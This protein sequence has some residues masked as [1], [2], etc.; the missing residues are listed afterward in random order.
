MINFTHHWAIR[1]PSGSLRSG[2]IVDVMKA[3]GRGQYVLLGAV[4]D[5]GVTA[6]ALQA[7]DQGPALALE[8]NRREE[9]RAAK[10]RTHNEERDRARFE[11]E[12]AAKLAR[13][14]KDHALAGRP[15]FDSWAQRMRFFDDPRLSRLANAWEKRDGAYPAPAAVLAFVDGFPSEARDAVLAPYASPPRTPAPELPPG[16]S[17]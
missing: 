9:R 17:V 5:D 16:V 3:N 6:I 4:Q 15:P 12:N 10:L 8:V 14:N 1:G 11:R 7:F 13:I 2:Q